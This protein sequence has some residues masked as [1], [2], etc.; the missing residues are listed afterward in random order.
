P[1]GA[2]SLDRASLFFSLQVFLGVCSGLRQSLYINGC[3]AIVHHLSHLAPIPL[4][5]RI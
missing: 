3:V 1:C 5:S 2:I 4:V